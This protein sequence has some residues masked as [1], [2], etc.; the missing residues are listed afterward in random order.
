MPRP[1][2]SEYLINLSYATRSSIVL[3][4]RCTIFSVILAASGLN[5]VAAQWLWDPYGDNPTTA[6]APTAAATS[7]AP[8]AAAAAR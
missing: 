3:S 4:M 1:F 6:A 7:A 8:S 2:F 5:L